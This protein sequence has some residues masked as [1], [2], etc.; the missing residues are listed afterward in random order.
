[1]LYPLPHA[2]IQ[3]TR[4]RTHWDFEILK[5][6]HLRLMRVLIRLNYTGLNY[7]HYELTSVNS[8]PDNSRLVTN[9]QTFGGGLYFWIYLISTILVVTAKPIVLL[10][11][12]M[13]MIVQ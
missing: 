10:L 2:E 4:S 5:V 13:F 7:A 6:L 8:L 9:D 12:T 1:M 11:Y 3:R